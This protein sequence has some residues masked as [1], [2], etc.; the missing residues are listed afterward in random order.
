MLRQTQTAKCLDKRLMVLGF[1]VPDL[2]AICLFLSALHL[3]LGDLGNSLVLV[4]LPSVTFAL[5][6][7]FGKRGKAENFLIHWAQFHLKPGTLS[8][9]EPAMKWAPYKGELKW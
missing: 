5:V 2:L 4:W 7:W 8:A 1:E 9:F 3:V 6:L